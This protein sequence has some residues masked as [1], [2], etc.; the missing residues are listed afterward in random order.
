M[1]DWLLNQ[2]IIG[3]ENERRSTLNWKSKYTTNKI[4]IGMTL[5]GGNPKDTPRLLAPYAETFLY[6]G[7]LW[8]IYTSVKILESLT[9]SYDSDVLDP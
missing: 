3:N 9:H 5:F 7:Q 1:K 8:E 6:N 2:P 4:T